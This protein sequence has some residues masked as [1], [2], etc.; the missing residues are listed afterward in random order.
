MRKVNVKE[1][2]DIARV[3]YSEVVSGTPNFC[4]CSALYGLNT[5]NTRLGVKPW[6]VC[7]CADGAEQLIR[8]SLY[9]QLSHMNLPMKQCD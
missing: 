2:W 4:S 5:V 3:F 6:W 9:L 1:L 7:L 8:S